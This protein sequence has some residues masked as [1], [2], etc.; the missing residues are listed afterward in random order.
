VACPQYGINNKPYIVIISVGPSNMDWGGG[1]GSR[2]S[3]TTGIE[4]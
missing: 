2:Q 4:K 1:R 3:M